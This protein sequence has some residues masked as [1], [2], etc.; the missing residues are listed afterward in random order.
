MKKWWIILIIL[1]V[2]II[3]IFYLSKWG[4]QTI[5]IDKKIY[6]EGESVKIHWSNFG[7]SWCSC[8][9]RDIEIWYKEDSELWKKTKYALGGFGEMVC[10]NGKLTPSSMP[11]DVV[12]CSFPKPS[13][14]KGDFI[15]NS[16]VYEKT[17]NVNN[18]KDVYGRDINETLTNY[19]F[20][21]APLGEYKIRFGTAKK[22][23]EIR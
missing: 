4:I 3:I 8:D 23:F 9:N 6:S 7:I 15:W 2:L 1:F 19:E 22:T 18:C 10:V 20:R 21:N 12:M 5:S 14:K 11:C 16:K 13:L 17:G